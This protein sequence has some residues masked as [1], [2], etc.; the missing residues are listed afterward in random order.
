MASKKILS[1][2][3]VVVFL[4]SSIYF[5][6]PDKVRIDIEDTRTKYSVWENESWVLAATEYV[7]LYDGTTKMRAKSRELSYWNDSENVYVNRTSIWKDN[8]TTIQ[9]YTFFKNAENVEDFPIKNEFTCINCVGKIVHYEIRDIL[10]DGDT[11]VIESPFSFG[12]NMKME[13]QEGSYYSKVFQQKSSDKIIV[14]YRP[15]SN[16][17]IYNVRLFDP[18]EQ[19]N[20]HESYDTGMSSLSY[21]YGGTGVGQLFTVG[22]S[23]P[24]VDFY[25]PSASI[26]LKKKGNPGIVTF[27]LSEIDGSNNPS[28]TICSKTIDGDALPTS[29]T[30]YTIDFS[31]MS[32]CKLEAST[33][34]AVYFKVP[35]GDTN[36][37]VG[38][39]HNPTG[40]YAGGNRVFFQSDTWYT[41]SDTDLGFEIYGINASLFT[42]IELN[43]QYNF[44][45]NNSGLYSCVDI[46]HPEYGINYTCG[47][48]PFNVSFNI[49]YFREDE[50]IYNNTKNDSINLTFV[51]SSYCSDGIF[52]VISSG[53]TRFFS[54]ER[55]NVNINVDAG[56]EINSLS[57]YQ[58]S[59]VGNDSNV[60]MKIC[61]DTNSDRI[62]DSGNAVYDGECSILVDGATPGWKTCE[63][64]STI[65]TV[66]GDYIAYFLQNDSSGIFISKISVDNNVT[67]YETSETQAYTNAW[68]DVA[69]RINI[70][71]VSSYTIYTDVHQYDEFNQL[72]LNLTS[73][74]QNDSFLSGINIYI[75]DTLSNIIGFIG[76]FILKTFSTGRL[77]ETIEYDSSG[78][79]AVYIDIPKET[80]F[81]GNTFNITGETTNTSYSYSNA[82]D[83]TFD[84]ITFPTFFFDKDYVV[85]DSYNFTV[86]GTMLMGSGFSNQTFY[87]YLNGE[88]IDEKV[89]TGMAA[90]GTDKNITFQIPIDNIIEGENS[91]RFECVNCECSG[92]CNNPADSGDNWYT[93][94]DQGFNSNNPCLNNRWGAISCHIEATGREVPSD[95]TVHVGLIDLIPNYQTTGV[96]NITTNVSNFTSD[97]ITFL[98]VCTADEFGFCLVPFHTF[99]STKGAI[100]FN[101]LSVNYTSNPNPIILDSTL[102]GS[103]INNSFGDNS[104]PISIT[105]LTPGIL[106]IDDFKYD[107][108]GGKDAIEI[109][110]YEA[111]NVS[112]K[113]F[114]WL[115]NYY[116]NWNYALPS[117]IQYFEIIPSTPTSSSVAP[118][119]QSST[120]PILNITNYGYGGMASNFSFYLNGSHECVNLTMSLTNNQSDAFTLNDSWI[121]LFNFNYLNSTSLW[122]WADYNCNYSTWKLWQPDFYFRNCCEDCICTQELI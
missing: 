81:D 45:V 108:A 21:K 121:D 111:A 30:M 112:N 74:I 11:S 29:S 101:N 107:Y 55:V 89:L 58:H 27:Y 8:I 44:T 113:Y 38:G 65:I 33:T 40:T 85:W 35:G 6:M 118:Y 41:S 22:T 70:E 69:L 59:Q 50:F 15:Q 5:M 43:S 61:K 88:K 39:Y 54:N 105:S 28:T 94:Y 3:L 73:I 66:S 20:V 115:L 17:E 84:I 116:S 86:G 51:G 122:M 60:T 91:I 93:A 104:L 79:E 99:S 34:Y 53:G 62:C 95:V 47:I 16:Y 18:P 102:I 87:L 14:K 117:P 48:S 68:D 92:G 56:L 31:D 78:T 37:A 119:G 76:N 13:W 2:F 63:L 9:T 32:D 12:H 25:S 106:I 83:G 57:Y 72:S 120:R 67:Y 100:T 36:N 23:S 7:N 103:F 114:S 98:N 52:C 90:S 82:F 75:N 1:A 19:A 97:L 24:D 80:D 49:S 42:L 46:D 64:N 109:M 110:V 96:F 26:R 71:N 10:Y 4:A 77:E